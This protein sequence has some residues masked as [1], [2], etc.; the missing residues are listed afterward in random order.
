MFNQT[1]YTMLTNRQI[2]RRIT[3][4]FVMG[5]PVWLGFGILIAVFG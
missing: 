1:Q 3:I 2:I 5:I 4:G